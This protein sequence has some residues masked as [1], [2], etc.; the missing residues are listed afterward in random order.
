MLVR[1]LPISY[2]RFI[3]RALVISLLSMQSMAC[4]PWPFSGKGDKGKA[5]ARQEQVEPFPT[6][7]DKLAI[8][9]VVFS[10]VS[11]GFFHRDVRGVID[12]ST[13]PSNVGNEA[14]FQRRNP[15]SMLITYGLSMYLL[16]AAFNFLSQNKLQLPGGN[17]HQDQIKQAL[18]RLGNLNPA[19]AQ[20]L[21][22]SAMDRSTREQVV[23]LA[24]RLNGILG[25]WSKSWQNSAPDSSYAGRMR[26]SIG[27][28]LSLRGTW[29]WLIHIATTLHN[30]LFSDSMRYIFRPEGMGAIDSNYLVRN[31][32]NPIFKDL[33]LAGANMF[34]QTARVMSQSPDQ[35]FSYLRSQVNT[36]VATKIIVASILLARCMI[37]KGSVSEISTLIPD[38]LGLARTR[39]TEGFGSWLGGLQ[40]DWITI[41]REFFG[42]QPTFVSEQFLPETDENKCNVCF[43]SHMHESKELRSFCGVNRHMFHEECLKAWFNTTNEN[44]QQCPICRDPLIDKGF[45]RQMLSDVSSLFSPSRYFSPGSSSTPSGAERVVHDTLNDLIN[46][47]GKDDDKDKE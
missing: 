8:L 1:F 14:A 6:N 27:T 39:Q 47:I 17:Q 31:V 43:E 37:L 41:T 23:G 19:T 33:E 24:S 7:L 45:M 46:N 15:R 28:L 16:Q 2:S 29:M 44:A 5:P 22:A 13:G 40:T 21:A 25:L 10:L 3:L 18:S 11:S 12:S 34:M 20:N 38:S 9:S 35:T 36:L 4:A 32:W 26:E 42:Y 30:Q